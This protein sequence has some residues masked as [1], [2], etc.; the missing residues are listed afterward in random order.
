MIEEQCFRHSEPSLIYVYHRIMMMGSSLMNFEFH[1]YL[2]NLMV[3]IE[4][5]GKWGGDRKRK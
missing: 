1:L 3:V 2:G 4:K 5:D